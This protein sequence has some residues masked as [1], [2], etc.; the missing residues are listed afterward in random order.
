MDRKQRKAKK[1]EDKIKKQK[2]HQEKLKAE[3]VTEEAKKSGNIQLLVFFGV[4]I[5]GAVI[6]ILNV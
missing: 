1:R 4:A 5:L 6:I 3:G 2:L